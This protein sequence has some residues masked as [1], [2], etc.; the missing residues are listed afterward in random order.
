MMVDPTMAP[1]TVKDFEGTRLVEGGS[2]QID[3]SDKHRM[4]SHLT[5]GIGYRT[6]IK[7]PVKKHYTP[8]GQKYWK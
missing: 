7:H 2:G 3:K 4:F 1:Y 8:S 5:D 6:W